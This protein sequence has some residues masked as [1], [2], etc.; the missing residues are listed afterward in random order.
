M[1]KFKKQTDKNKEGSIKGKGKSINAEELKSKANIQN[2]P[3]PVKSRSRLIKT[4]QETPSKETQI[5][6]LEEDPRVPSPTVISPTQ[7]PS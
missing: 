7:I 3:E 2:P 1:G 4:T 6:Y 5:F